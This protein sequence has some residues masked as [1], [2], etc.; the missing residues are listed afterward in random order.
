MVGLANGSLLHAQ[1][2]T[3]ETF[4]Y[5]IFWSLD[6]KCFRYSN[7][8]YSDPCES[9]AIIHKVPTLTVG[10]IAQMV[11]PATMLQRAV[12][13]HGVSISIMDTEYWILGTGY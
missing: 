1:C 12:G 4:E 5:Q 7:G 13:D 10:E 8:R 6:L 2:S 9:D 3:S 11:E